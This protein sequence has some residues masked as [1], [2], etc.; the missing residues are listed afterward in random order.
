MQF[1]S[2]ILACGILAAAQ[3]SAHEFWIEP[4]SSTTAQI[5]VG[6][7]LVGEPLPFLDRIIRSARHYSVDGVQ[8]LEGRQGDLPALTLDMTKPGLHLITVETAPAYIIFDDLAEFRDYLDYEGLGRVMDDHRSRGAP[9]RE[10]AEEYLRYAR[11]LSASGAVEAL[12][13]DV[14]TGLRYELVAATSP[15]T[16][17]AQTVKMQLL[18]EGQAQAGTQVSVFF[19]PENDPAGVTR[20]LLTSDADGRVVAGLKGPGL[21]LFNAVHMLATDGPG[22]VVWQSH[23][24]SLSFQ[25]GGGG[26]RE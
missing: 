13:A 14:P 24:A 3:A 23:W 16:T 7:M 19:R 9:D 25:L 18:W 11:T 22:S 5:R 20:E 21:Y 12:G 15:F 4:D 8:E 10:I 26:L 2:L 17:G 1:R 6:Q